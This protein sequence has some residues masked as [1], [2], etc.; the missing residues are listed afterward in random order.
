MNPQSIWDAARRARI[1]LAEAI[2]CEGKTPGQIAAICAD[3]RKDGHPVLMTRLDSTVFAALS[4]E[5]RGEADYDALSG[6]RCSAGRRWRPNRPAS[7]W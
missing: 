3:A 4:P 7:P 5:V 1:G 2:L 6:P